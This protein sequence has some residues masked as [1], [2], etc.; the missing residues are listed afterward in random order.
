M[1]VARAD[2][3]KAILSLEGDILVHST[4]NL[5]SSGSQKLITARQ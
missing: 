2:S 1:T 5:F 3:M 4:E